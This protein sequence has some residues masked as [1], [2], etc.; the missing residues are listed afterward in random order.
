MGKGTSDPLAFGGAEPGSVQVVESGLSGS[1]ATLPVTPPG[2]RP[3][4]P[5]YLPGLAIPGMGK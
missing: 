3:S 5:G 2:R 4:F 1:G